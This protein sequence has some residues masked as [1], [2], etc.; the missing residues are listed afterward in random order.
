MSRTMSREELKRQRG[1]R[2]RRFQT[3]DSVDNPLMEDAIPPGVVIWSV[4][5]EQFGS[6]ERSCRNK[7]PIYD[8]G[9]AMYAAIRMQM[10]GNPNQVYY[11]CEH[12]SSE[13]QKVYHLGHRQ[14]YGGEA[15]ERW[16]ERQNG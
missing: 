14:R 1:R 15:Y 2:Q 12:C 5:S 13:A 6:H 8:E 4:K 11:E 3:I 9:R 16:G 7:K 10:R